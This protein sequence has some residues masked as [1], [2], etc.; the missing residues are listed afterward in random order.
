MRMS[1]VNPVVFGWCLSRLLHYIVNL[2]RR[3][4]SSKIFLMKTDWNQAFRQGHLSAPNAAVSSCLATPETFHFSLRMIFGGR[5]NPSEWSNISESACNLVNALQTL[6]NFHPESYLH[7]IPETIPTKSPLD[8]DIH[9]KQAGHLSVNIEENDCG[10]SD[11]YLDDNIG[12]AP[13][14][15]DNVR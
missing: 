13:D 7:L 3:H 4:P 2:Q 1:E 11:I 15:W 9:F 14:L 12:I 10:K 6:P 5:A 8:K